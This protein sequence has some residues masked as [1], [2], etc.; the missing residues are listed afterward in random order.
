M[1]YII[2]NYNLPEGVGDD[3]PA[4]G[5][6]LDVGDAEGVALDQAEVGL[7]LPLAAPADTAAQKGLLLDV[8]L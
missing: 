1:F 2:T 8:M 5:D 6:L 4:D 7:L 3:V